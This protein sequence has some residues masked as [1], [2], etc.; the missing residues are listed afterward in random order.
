MMISN[1][2]N[3]ILTFILYF[4]CTQ[5]SYAGP[6]F[7]TDDPQPV[8]FKHFE[9]YISSQ[10]ILHSDNWS[11]TSPHVEINYGLVR[12]LQVHILLPVNY[13]YT[14]HM[15]TDF[16]YA[17]TEF[18]V[19]YCFIHET[20]NSPQIGIFPILEI[21]TIINS[22]F[23]NGKVQ[24]FLPVWVQKSWGKLTSYGGAGFCINPGVNNRNWIFTGAEIQYELSP[25]VMLGGELYYHSADVNGS[26]S[27]TACN[28]GGSIN[29]SQKLH[30]I[31]SVGHSLI[32]DNF[33]SSYFGLL[34]TI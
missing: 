27:I 6:P 1:K 21:P 9:F 22:E 32:N 24:V 30:F 31:F 34:L 20:D 33:T 15:G 19:K 5:L 4:L 29:F 13:S 11:G 26:K 16:G 17:N 23:S 18:G 28:I 25:V 10:N 12:D 14:P 8:D 3:S 2:K 7:L